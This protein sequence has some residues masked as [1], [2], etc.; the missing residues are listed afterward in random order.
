MTRVNKHGERETT[1]RGSSGG[2]ETETGRLTTTRGSSSGRARNRAG[3]PGDE[4]D[5]V[6]RGSA[7]FGRAEETP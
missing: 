3:G 7:P 6:H 2:R 5:G 4:Q 1:R